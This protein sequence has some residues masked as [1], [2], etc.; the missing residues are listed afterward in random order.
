MK[1]ELTPEIIKTNLELLRANARLSLYVP[2]ERNI[3][4]NLSNVLASMLVAKI[5][6]PNTIIEYLGALIFFPY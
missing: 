1:E 3:A 5:P 2:A 4:G 6:M